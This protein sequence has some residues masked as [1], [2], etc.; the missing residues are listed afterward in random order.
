MSSMKKFGCKSCGSY[1]VREKD[2]KLY[3]VSC[4]AFFTLESET[5][6]ER[7]ARILFLSRLDD[8]EKCLRIS[9]PRFDDAEDMYRDFIKQY[10]RQLGRLLGSCPREI[11]HK[12]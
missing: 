4:G 10:P 12:V 8:A 5:N 2:G 7:D 6:E 11:R 1:H 9:P 3:C